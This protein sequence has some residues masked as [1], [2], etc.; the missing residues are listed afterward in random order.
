MPELQ[1]P[2]GQ[3][4]DTGK[5]QYDLVP[6]ECLDELAKIMT[7]GC[8]KYGKPSGWQ[9]V[10]DME[11]RYFAALMRHISA[12]RRGEIFDAESGYRHLSHALCNVVFILW[13]QIQEDSNDKP[14]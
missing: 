12:Y 11:N 3:K 6:F 10:E 8:I 14:S 4:F 5:L 1:E 7:Y 9:F 13:Q 2:K